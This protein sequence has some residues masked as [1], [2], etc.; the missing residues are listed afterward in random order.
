MAVTGAVSVG[1]VVAIGP[2][3]PEVDLMAIAEEMKLDD[4]LSVARTKTV[5]LD[6]VS[7]KTCQLL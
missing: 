6:I 1:V 2:D 7:S 4:S 3:V 5:A